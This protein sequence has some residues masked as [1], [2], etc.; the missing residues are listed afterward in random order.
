ME[1]RYVERNEKGEVVGDYA[2]E[3]DFAKEILP[4]DH[5]DILAFWERQNNGTV[6]ASIIKSEPSEPGPIEL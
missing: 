1:M 4:A 5:P 2:C 6:H 3:Q